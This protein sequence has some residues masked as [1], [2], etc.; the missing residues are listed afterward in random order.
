MMRGDDQVI[1]VLKVVTGSYCIVNF[2]LNVIVSSCCWFI[3]HI[4][5]RTRTTKK[6]GACFFVLYIQK[7]VEGNAGKSERYSTK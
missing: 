1:A 4:N 3:V 7:L 2:E 6:E 5:I